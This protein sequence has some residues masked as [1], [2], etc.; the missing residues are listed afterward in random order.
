MPYPT[1]NWVAPLWW[2]PP[3]KHPATSRPALVAA[4][5]ERAAEPKPPRKEFGDEMKGWSGVLGSTKPWVAL[6]YT[7]LAAFLARVNIVV[8]EPDGWLAVSRLY[9]DHVDALA[10]FSAQYAAVAHEQRPR[11]LPNKIGD[12]V[13]CYAL[14]VPPAVRAAMVSAA[15]TDGTGGVVDTERSARTFTSDP[16]RHHA[17]YHRIA[18]SHYVST[19]RSKITVFQNDPEIARSFSERITALADFDTRSPLRWSAADEQL[20]DDRLATQVD[21]DTRLHTNPGLSAAYLRAR[22][23]MLRRTSRGQPLHDAILYTELRSARLDEKK[24]ERIRG[25]HETSVSADQ[26]SSFADVARPAREFLRVEDADIL[27]RA[28][29]VLADYPAFLPG[30]RRDCWEKTIALALLGGAHRAATT[31]ELR[32]VVEQAWQER[33]ATDRATS[34]TSK[35]AAKLVEAL[36]FLAVSQSIQIGD[37]DKNRAGAADRI[38]RRQVDTDAVLHRHGLAIDDLQD[39]S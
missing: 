7:K 21:A 18:M 30:T 27:S 9:A 31:A 29:T 5:I 33:A 16:E 38:A 25:A 24:A 37:L 17:A 6:V 20:V 23:T 26:L 34:A 12:N 15:G 14:T 8:D 4:W 32:A 13:K 1:P 10:R 19:L 3:P 28:A 36:L 11:G 35:T 22:K 39:R 2:A